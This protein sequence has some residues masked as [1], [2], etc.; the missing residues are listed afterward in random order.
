VEGRLVYIDDVMAFAY[1]V[2]V[3]IN[4]NAYAERLAYEELY[5]GDEVMPLLICRSEDGML[6]FSR[7]R[8]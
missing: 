8:K 1:T 3:V 2:D 4:Y 5:D 6:E 7:E